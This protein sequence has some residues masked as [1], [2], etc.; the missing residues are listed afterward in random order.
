MCAKTSLRLKTIAIGALFAS[1][2][3]VAHAGFVNLNNVSGI[4]WEIQFSP[5][6]LTVKSNPGSNNLDWLVFEDFFAANSTDAGNEI[7]TPQSISIDVNGGGATSFDVNSSSGT[8]SIALGGIDQNDLF[9]NIAQVSASASAGDTVVVT[10]NGTGVRFTSTDVPALNTSWNGQVA[11]WSN[12]FPM[13]T[14]NSFITP[15]PEPSTLTLAGLGLFV[16]ASRRKRRST[17]A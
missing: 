15:V 8:F 16:T 14:E 12:T 3:S 4:E 6:T 10:Q 7:A 2:T 13:V 1:C 17:G 11:F 5:I 9:I